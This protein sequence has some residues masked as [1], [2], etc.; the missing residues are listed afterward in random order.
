MALDVHTSPHPDPR[1]ATT[2]P[3]TA[4][5]AATR[6]AWRDQQRLTELC[7][8]HGHQLVIYLTART[9]DPDL[10]QDLAQETLT[11]AAANLDQLDPDRPAW[12][13]LKATATNLAVDHHRKHAR[14]QLTDDLTHRPDP[15][16]PTTAVIERDLLD[17]ALAAIPD[18]QRLAIELRYV[19]QWN[20]R[21]ASSL[22]GITRTAFEQLLFRA[23]M[24]LRDAYGDL[25]EHTT[26]RTAGLLLPLHHLKDSLV[27]R[28]RTRLHGWEHGLH[29]MG[30]ATLD[31]VNQAA[32]IAILSLAT[33]TAIGTADRS[34]DIQSTPTNYLSANVEEP[35][36]TASAEARA[37][38]TTPVG[39]TTPSEPQWHV[40]FAPP[41][42]EQTRTV[43]GAEGSVTTARTESEQVVSNEVVIHVEAGENGRSWTVVTVT[44]DENPV[45]A[46]LCDAASG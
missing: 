31:A 17:A 15:T 30:P 12:P 34:V 44:C 41:T 5:T 10:A 16:D 28:I 24:S 20:A 2:P 4:R 11:R 37:R 1:P 39:S 29:A 19:E 3:A 43:V 21:E 33:L 27:A 14:E 46:A 32:T 25:T 6:A 9:G 7:Q 36:T 40:R 42:N 38:V 45:R 13:W 8:L 18:R 35:H 26:T 23:R 22:F